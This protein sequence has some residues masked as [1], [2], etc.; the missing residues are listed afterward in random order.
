VPERSSNA[1]V[2]IEQP[3]SSRFGQHGVVDPG[4]GFGVA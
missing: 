2:N 3:D 1:N 4:D